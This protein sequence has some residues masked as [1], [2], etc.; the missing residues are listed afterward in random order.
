MSASAALGAERRGRG[1]QRVAHV[2]AAGHAQRHAGRAFRRGHLHVPGVVGPARARR[3]LGTRPNGIG[4]LGQRETQAAAA[5]GLGLPDVGVLVV[6]REH[7]DA[8]GRQCLDRGTVLA[9]HGLDGAHEFLVL[10][11]RVVDQRHRGLRDARQHGDLARVVHAQFDDRGLVRCAQLQDRQ[12]HADVVVQVAGR[13]VRRVAER[14]TQDG[15]DHLRDGGLAVAA[16]DRDHRAREAPAPSGGQR[17]QRRQRIVDEDP[18][19]AG[20]G[21]AMRGDRRDGAG[22]ACLRQE[23]IRVEPL[24]LQRHEQVARAQRARVGVHALERARAVA[25]ECRTRHHRNSLRKRHERAHA[26]KPRFFRP[27]SASATSENGRRS[28]LISW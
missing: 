15:R 22:S 3:D 25:D 21:D 27:V 10:A 20:L 11:L 18:G 13:R 26:V 28:P 4:F 2:V 12:R 9:R 16:G 5:A 14:G 6:A 19:D 7:G 8:V 17:L 1:R 23:V 24:A